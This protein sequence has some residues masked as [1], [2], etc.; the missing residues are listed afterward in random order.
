MQEK[1]ELPAEVKAERKGGKIIISGESGPEVEKRLDHPRVNITIR[2]E[3]ILLTTEGVSKQEKSL[4]GTFRSII[5]NMVEGVQE[6]YT[7]QLKNVYA[8]FPAS[9]KVQGNKVVIENFLGERQPRRV[10][11]EAG[12]NVEVDDDQVM[13]RGP[14]KEKVGLVAGRIEQACY[15]GNFDPRKFQDGVYITNKG[16]N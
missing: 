8:H 16:S 1:V 10:Q 14:D 5:D 2:E 4:L 11:I 6:E 3:E 7:Y 13:V 12:V 15:K 9:V